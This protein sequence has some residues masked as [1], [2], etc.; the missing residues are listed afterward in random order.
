[1]NIGPSNPP[2]TALVLP[3]CWLSTCEIFDG[4]PH[5]REMASPDAAGSTGGVLQR[6][7]MLPA[8]TPPGEPPTA[9]SE[10]TRTKTKSQLTPNH[11]K[12]LIANQAHLL[13]GGVEPV[14]SEQGQEEEVLDYRNKESRPEELTSDQCP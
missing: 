10:S 1:M 5:G 8:P 3:D 2:Q 4:E 9:R 14:D 6:L 7:C 11:C 13:P 12:V